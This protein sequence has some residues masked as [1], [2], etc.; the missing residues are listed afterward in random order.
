MDLLLQA[1]AQQS[2]GKD[3]EK[4]GL[5]R[6]RSQPG[7]SCQGPW[8]PRCFLL[9][10]PP[11]LAR[12]AWGEAGAGHVA[13]IPIRVSSGAAAPGHR[14][15]N[16]LVPV[17]LLPSGGRGPLCAFGEIPA[18]PAARAALPHRPWEPGVGNALGFSCRCCWQRSRLLGTQEPAPFGFLRG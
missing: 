4:M 12:P 16:A 11:A 14:A 13:L 1:Q 6:G 7:G 18:Q 10:P 8:S 5:K 17:A 9:P 15:V 2:P 3:S